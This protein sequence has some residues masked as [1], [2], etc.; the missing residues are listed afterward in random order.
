MC[1]FAGFLDASGQL[2][3]DGWRDDLRRMGDA[4][5]HRGPD[6]AG[7]WGDV[8]AGVGLVHR[9]LAI[10]DLS[11]AGHQPML[12]ASGRYVLAFNGEIYNHRQ[13]RQRLDADGGAGD[14]ALGVRWRGHSDTETLL[15]AI[16]AWGVAAALRA[17]VGMFALALWDRRERSLVLA[18]DRMGE[19]PLYY[20]VQRGVLLFGSELKAL[21]AHAAFA[22]DIDR[23]ALAQQLQFSCIPA[24]H[25]IYEGIRKLMPGTWLTLCV[26]SLDAEPTA[27]WS[28][29]DTVVGARAHPFEGT[30]AEAVAALDARLRESLA[31]QMLADVPL[32]AFLSGGIDSS[33]VV[34]LMVA[35]ASTPVKTFT[36]GFQEQ[37]YSEAEQAAAV[38]RHLGTQHTALFV[39]H[40]DAREIIPRLPTL[41]DEPFS[42]SSQ[43]PS[44]LV[45]RMT[46]AHV[47][48][49]LSGDGGDELFGGYNR[50]F[51]SG[52]LW[53][54]LR[55]VPVVVRRLAA[56]LVTGVAPATWDRCYGWL[57]PHLSERRRFVQPG[58]KMHKLAGI[59]AAGSPDAIY[60]GLISHWQGD[61]CVLG[62]A[63]PAA[64]QEPDPG[65]GL[66]LEERMMY[67]D[68]LGY[69]AD[70]IL[71]KVD[72]AA[73]G[74]S[75]ETRI[76]FLDHRVLELAWR[77]PLHMKIRNGQGK[78]ILRQLLQRYVPRELIE[79]PKMGF[80]VP[81]DAWLRG[82]LRDWAEG[83]LAETRLRREGFLAPGPI[84]RKWQEH[85]S[86]RRNWQY[87][88]WDVLMFQA[89]LEQERR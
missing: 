29:R 42:D 25:S 66:G 36:I 56:R 21:R 7:V 5:A 65:M 23:G 51:L 20:G 45:A 70:D 39:T 16:E 89:W 28:L 73:M 50:Y 30:D 14:I 72:R 71:V 38:A 13:L 55:H 87:P 86:G 24:P 47:T 27:Y 53:Q 84:R 34:A 75:L 32:G 19:K 11:S 78:W 10:V 44:F 52:A 8:E 64:L 17:T 85:L 43:I 37:A 79:R 82:P 74:V 60:H 9:R 61:A 6:D 77:L 68:M 67:R 57:A 88:L 76:P 62:G 80:A 3:G 31:Q 22:A 15:A 41:Y 69:L 26:G 48:V 54:R 4:I 46:R 35:Q 12:S 2:S 33:T 49:A 40:D 83:L 58:D 81:I 18:R 63:A 1:G 59:L